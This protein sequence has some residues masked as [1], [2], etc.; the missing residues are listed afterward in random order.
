MDWPRFGGAFSLCIAVFS[1]HAHVSGMATTFTKLGIMNAALRSQG[2]MPL[3]TED[4]GSLEWGLLDANWAPLLES[5][6]QDGAF[7]FAVTEEELPT[8][9]GGGKFGY[10][11]AYTTPTEAL[12]VRSAFTEDTSGYRTNLDFTVGPTQ[13]HVNEATGIWVQYVEAV[14]PSAFSPLLALGLQQKLEAVIL[15]GLKEEYVAAREMEA[16]AESNLQRARSNSSAAKSPVPMFKR[17]GGR[18]GR[19][20]FLNG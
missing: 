6:L 9:A 5:I 11:D 16:M 17:G 12:L 20:R 1:P 13:T 14:E 7:N 3:A 15:R 18:I 2:E 4:D 19:S 10:D 8:R